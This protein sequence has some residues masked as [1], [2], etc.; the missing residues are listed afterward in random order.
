MIKTRIT[1]LQA[2]HEFVFNKFNDEENIME[3]LTYG[4]PDCP[5]ES[6]YEFIAENEENF[7]EIVDLFNRLCKLEDIVNH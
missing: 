5:N 1:I 4:V 7:N 2:M 6:D 3:W